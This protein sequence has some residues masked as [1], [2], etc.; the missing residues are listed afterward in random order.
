VLQCNRITA[1][2]A[3]CGTCKGEAGIGEK[4]SPERRSDLRRNLAHRTVA[5]IMAGLAIL[6]ILAGCSGDATSVTTP[7][8]NGDPVASTFG[9][10]AQAGRTVY[11]NNCA[12][13]HGGNGQGGTGPSLL[14]PV[15]RLGKYQNAGSL[16]DRI[17]STMP[18][19]APGSLAQRDYL[20]AL[21]YLLI[22]DGKVSGEIALVPARLSE[23]LLE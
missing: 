19:N 15:A 9:E 21:A 1:G 14:G 3:P 12:G 23:I 16:L 2:H 22:S 11:A 6:S 10:A 20:N 4:K 18:R 17:R 7:A 13:C 5:M 8:K